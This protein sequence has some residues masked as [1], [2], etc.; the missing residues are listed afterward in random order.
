MTYA[1]AIQ[2][3]CR[4]VVCGALTLLV[5]LWS[6]SAFAQHDFD[7]TTRFWIVWGLIEGVL[8][9]ACIGSIVLATRRK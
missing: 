9:V 2:V 3:A 6:L 4:V 5:L 7:R 8:L 1:R